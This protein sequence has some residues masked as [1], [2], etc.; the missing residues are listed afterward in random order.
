[1][2]GF[3]TPNTEHESTKCTSRALLSVREGDSL[4]GP[5]ASLLEAFHEVA[6]LNFQ[7]ETVRR[8]RDIGRR[9]SRPAGTVVA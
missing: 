5:G 6:L 9:H 4:G 8:G 7:V 1:M 3:S 2:G